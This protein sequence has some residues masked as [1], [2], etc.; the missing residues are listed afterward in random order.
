MFEVYTINAGFCHGWT[1]VYV[2]NVYKYNGEVK[3]LKYIFYGP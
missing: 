2:T 1:P 3:K